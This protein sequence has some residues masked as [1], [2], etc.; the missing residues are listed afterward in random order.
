MADDV[1]G[2]RRGG[3]PLRAPRRG[4]A[5]ADGPAASSAATPARSS[6]LVYDLLNPTTS[7]VVEVDS[8]SER[9][10]HERDGLPT[11]DRRGVP[12]RGGHL[13]RLEPPQRRPA[14]PARSPPPGRPLHGDDLAQGAARSNGA[15]HPRP[16]SLAEPRAVRRLLPRR[17]SAA[18]AELAALR[19]KATLAAGL[20]LENFIVKS[21][22][23][24]PQANA[25]EKQTDAAMER[26]ISSTQRIFGTTLQIVLYERTRQRARGGGPGD[27]RRAVAGPRPAR[28]PRDVSPAGGVPLAAAGGDAAG[29]AAPQDADSRDGRHAADLG[30]PVAARARSRSSRRTTGSSSTTRS[31]PARSPTRTSS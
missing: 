2:P 16:A 15:G 13:A 27:A 23:T 3:E 28:L 18:G 14:D 19:A 20:K 5:V 17:H 11:I 29:R 6:R 22:R 1:R 4:R 30:I 9:A 21:D 7:G 8:L 12:V 10:R 24:D 31:T 26:I 25:V